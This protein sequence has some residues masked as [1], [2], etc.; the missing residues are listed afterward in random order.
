MVYEERVFGGGKEFV[1]LVYLKC[2]AFTDKLQRQVLRIQD[3]YKVE[4][5]MNIWQA[6]Q[7]TKKKKEQA[8][9]SRR[10]TAG[11]KRKTAGARKWFGT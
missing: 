6:N 4:K 8:E 7:K 11:S 5:K 1:N 3:K 10:K 9:G 2:P